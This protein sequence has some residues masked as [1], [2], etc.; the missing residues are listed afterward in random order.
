MLPSKKT[1]SDTMTIHERSW[2][3]CPYDVRVAEHLWALDNP[4]APVLLVREPAD[5][6][7][8]G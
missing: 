1:L 3:F 5:L 8:P 2:A 7:A 6:P 4:E